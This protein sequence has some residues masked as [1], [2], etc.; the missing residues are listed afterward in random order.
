M[1]EVEPLARSVP[2]EK[3]LHSLKRHRRIERLRARESEDRVVEIRPA[4]AIARAAL[5]GK[6][7]AEKIAH[8]PR[9]VAEEARREAGDLEEL[10]AKAHV[11][12]CMRS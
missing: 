1:H 11:A 6:L 5:G 8:Q 3:I 7:P 12:C 2:A 4:R 10:K 9:G